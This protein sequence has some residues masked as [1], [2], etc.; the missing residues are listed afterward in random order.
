M[1]QVQEAS[2][3][4]RPSPPTSTP[5]PLDVSPAQS[6]EHTLLALLVA[7]ERSLASEGRRTG[8]RHCQLSSCRIGRRGQTRPS[9]LRSCVPSLVLLTLMRAHAVAA[10]APSLPEPAE[11][12]TNQLHGP[13]SRRLTRCQGGPMC[14]AGPSKLGARE[15]RDPGRGLRPPL[16]RRSPSSDVLVSCH[17]SCVGASGFAWV[18]SLVVL[19][20]HLMRDS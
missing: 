3:F 6:G 10:P 2:D 18:R 1:V 14:A 5:S 9:R 12:S 8:G 16:A 17:R 15:R 13:I 4:L 11:Q 19:L 7:S 20:L